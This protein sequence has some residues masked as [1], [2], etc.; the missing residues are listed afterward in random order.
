ME[1]L[2]MIV[3]G[4]IGQLRRAAGMT[5]LEMAEKLNYSDKAISKWERGESLPDLTVLV[6]V[7][8]MFG[9]SVDYLLHAE[10][11][12]ETESRREYTRRQK[13]NHLLIAAMSIMLVWL[14]ATFA[15]VNIDLISPSLTRHWLA[16]VYALPVSSV[17]ALVFNSIWGAR[18]RQFLIISVLLWSTLATVYLTML[19]HNL[20]LIFVIGVPA[21]IIILLWAGLKLK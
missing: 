8:D 14:V 13:R 7:A 21:Q 17:V 10:H 19:A 2:R 20:W 1:E 6:Q 15:F 3:A 4:N 12:K 9:V 5:Q 16:F 11:P 18:K